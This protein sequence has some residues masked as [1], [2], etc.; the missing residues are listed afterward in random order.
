MNLNFQN[1]S[2]KPQVLLKKYIYEYKNDA[3]SHPG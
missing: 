1:I 3:R 2:P